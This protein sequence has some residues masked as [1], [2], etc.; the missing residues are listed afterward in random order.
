[1]HKKRILITVKTYPTLS[2]K[3]NELVCTA[4]FDEN[5]SWIRLYPVPFRRLDYENQYKKYSII[6]LDVIKNTKD[7]RPESFRPANVDDI[8]VVAEIPPDG[9]TWR[10]RRKLVLKTVHDNMEKIIAEA[11]DQNIQTS[12]AV[13]KPTK[14]IDFTFEETERNWDK[15]TL[16]Y[17]EANMDQQDLFQDTV[18]L[19]KVVKKLPYKFFYKFT[20]KTGKECN[21]SIIDWE[22]GTLF[23]NCLKKYKD[24]KKACEKVKQKYFDDF[25][26][27]KDLHFF[28][29]T[30]KKFHSWGNN[31]FIIIGT[32]HPKPIIQQELGLF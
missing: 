2:K 13:F 3:Y 28:L 4:G 27:T 30:T 19:F 15:D 17:I 22:V 6:E 29:G 31:P 20:D 10:E 23:W 9:D 5:G 14:I 25:A 21:L 18:S 11:Q 32:F 24:E 1:M 8:Q 16:E 26:V 7:F 12:L